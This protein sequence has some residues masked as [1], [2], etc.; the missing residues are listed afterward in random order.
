MNV[1]FVSWF[2]NALFDP[3]SPTPFG[4][5]EVRCAHLARALAVRPGH[6]VT[7]VVGEE[8]RPPLGRQGD[9]EVLAA[10]VPE[11]TPSLHQ[12][13][14]ARFFSHLERTPV[15]PGWRLR[16][17]H[18]D[19]LSQLPMLLAARLPLLRRRLAL[20]RPQSIELFDQLDCDVVCCFKVS[21][22]SASVVATCRERGLPSVLFLAH[23]EDVSPTYV[24]GSTHRHSRH[25]VDPLCWDALVGANRIVAQTRHQQELLSEHFGLSSRL[26]RNPVD[27]VAPLAAKPPA[28]APHVVWIGRAEN[29]Y[30]R[31]ELCLEL[32]RRLS[33]RRFLMIAGRREPKLFDQLCRAAPGNVRIVERL[34]FA[35]AEAAIAAASA[36]INT[37]SREGFPNVFLQAAKHSVPIVS[38]EVD[39]DGFLSHHGCGIVAGGDLGRMAEQL[40]RVCTEPALAASLGQTAR[41]YVTAHHDLDGRVDELAV[42]LDEMAAE[43]T[44]RRFWQK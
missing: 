12:Q 8:G 18:P 38:L 40:E 24:F 41:R 13:A 7:L 5:A 6:T 16:R 25:E 31:P 27:L 30:K 28:G 43:K 14:H 11:R 29:A 39:P 20:P 9:L 34:D 26:I 22:L 15:F 19:L 3:G 37:S 2:A 10:P 23:D 21:K 32:A 1:C 44:R 33:H 4:G 35:H 17:F 36:V 42:L